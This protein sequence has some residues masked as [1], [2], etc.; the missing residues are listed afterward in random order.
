MFP[1]NKLAEVFI[2]LS[3]SEAMIIRIMRGDKR[4]EARD[5]KYCGEE[6]LDCCDLRIK[7]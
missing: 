6:Q 1:M 3:L 7:Q 5:D 4:K 2:Q